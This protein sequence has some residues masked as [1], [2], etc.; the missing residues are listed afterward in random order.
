[1]ETPGRGSAF[2]R[3]LAAAGALALAAG[4][5]AGCGSGS[6]GTDG[7]GA[8]AGA[9]SSNGSAAGVTA[10]GRIVAQASKP[11]A[12]WNGF[13]KPVAAPSG[14][15]IVAIECSSLGVGCVQGANAT[16]E[17]ASV[18]GWSTDVVNGK[19]DPT[20]WNAAIQ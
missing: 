6:S 17:A 18:L 1:F 11:I 8:G 10:A 5:A 2:G 7:S 19:G 15:H 12:S 9:P 20:V 16:R 3:T 4:I 13:G 14:K